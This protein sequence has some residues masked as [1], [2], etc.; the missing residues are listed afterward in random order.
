MKKMNRRKQRERR[1]IF[2]TE[3]QRHKE[4]NSRKRTQ[5]TQRGTGFDR[6]KRSQAE[7]G[8]DVGNGVLECWSIGVLGEDEGGCAR[9]IEP[10]GW[11]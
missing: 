8:T 4:G 2:T 7:L 9:W 10:M 3:R 1:G 11:I 5:G 6:R